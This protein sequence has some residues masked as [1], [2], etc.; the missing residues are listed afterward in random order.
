MGCSPHMKLIPYV[1]G[2]TSASGVVSSIERRS[3]MGA[4]STGR[5]LRDRHR[6]ARSQVKKRRPVA[7]PFRSPPNRNHLP[8]A[9]DPA[10]AAR[11]AT[12]QKAERLKTELRGRKPGALRNKDARNR[13]IGR[14]TNARARVG[15][16]GG[17]Y[18]AP[19]ASRAMKSSALRTLMPRRRA[20]VSARVAES[21][22]SQLW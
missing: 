11:L 22:Q 17:A 5:A 13:K 8:L 16:A 2:F 14:A 6:L 9:A 1:L 15:H 21:R 18:S 19:G 12:K 10:H 7:T 20:C 3:M 4:A